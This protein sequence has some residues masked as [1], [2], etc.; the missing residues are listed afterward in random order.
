MFELFT[1]V[2]CVLF[3]R[4]LSFLE[5]VSSLLHLNNIAFTVSK[6]TNVFLLYDEDEP[7]FALLFCIHC[8]RLSFVP[9]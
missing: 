2:C 4:S 5:F 8:A 7:S 9:P 6:I 1:L 3:S